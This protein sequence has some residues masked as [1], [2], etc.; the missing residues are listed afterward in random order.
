MVW[1]WCCDGELDIDS[2]SGGS[3]GRAL[4]AEEQVCVWSAEAGAQVVFG[5]VELTKGVEP[6]EVYS[7]QVI[8]RVHRLTGTQRLAGGLNSIIKRGGKETIR[9]YENYCVINGAGGGT[10][11]VSRLSEN[12]APGMCRHTFRNVRV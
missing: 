2:A 5:P 11:G 3:G 9:Q 1:Q 12:C 4:N 7:Y 10:L 8:A 6:A